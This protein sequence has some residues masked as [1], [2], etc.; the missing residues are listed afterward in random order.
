MSSFVDLCRFNP[1]AG[2]LGDFV[3]SSAVAGCQ[4]PT[5]ANAQNG[6]SYKC[7][8]ISPDLSQWELFQGNYNSGTG[9]FPRTTV[10]YNS[11]GTGTAAGQSGAG[12]KINFA[13][14][15][16]VAVVALFE[17][18]LNYGNTI[19]PFTG[20]VTIGGTLGVVGLTSLANAT[21]TG[22]LG[23]TGIATFTVAPVFT[24]PIGSA[25][26]LS[27]VS[28]GSA[29]SL[30]AAQQLLVTSDLGVPFECGQLT[31]TS[32][33]A[34][35]FKPYKGDLLKIN[36]AVFRIPAAGI[37]GLGAPTSVFLNGVAAQTLVAATTYF[38]YAFS[39]AGVVTAD[40]SVTG[41]STSSTTGNIGT[42]IKTG[43]DTR[44]LIGMVRTGATVVYAS[45]IQ[46][47]SWFNRRNK[48]ATLA[49][50]LVAAG[51]TTA[52]GFVTWLEEAFT[53]STA[54]FIGNSA[55]AVCGMQNR[56]DTVNVGPSI[57]GNCT[58]GGQIPYN[59]MIILTSTEGNHS[60]DAALSAG[61]GTPQTG[62]NSFVAIRG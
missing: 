11:S 54:G 16:Q 2:G 45:D 60:Y 29:Q 34:L 52:M 36:G 57:Q 50:N 27:A 18:L 6:V 13:T 20:N 49:Q 4:S 44:T 10:L 58:A 7:Y 5:A 40:F 61:A 42:E 12:T 56:I 1:V 37:A 55:L 26:A 51:N 22:T 41:H 59:T 47:A 32:T 15:P 23:V 28:Y 30:T 46:T 25:N 35:A 53:I 17:D 31:F 19:N 62:G 14:I 21:L 9:T 38:I 33:A 24:D 48:V 8:A 43:D 3:Y 39:N